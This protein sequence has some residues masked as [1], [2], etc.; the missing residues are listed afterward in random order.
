LPEDP[1][2][3]IRLPGIGRYTAGAVA[4]FAYEKAVPAVDTNVARV[5]RRV[6]FGERLIRQRIS[7]RRPIRQQVIWSLAAGLVPKDGKRAWKFNQ[8]IMELG[9]LICGARK[10]K[11][12]DCPVQVRCRTGRRLGRRQDARH[13]GVSLNV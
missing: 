7:R 10:P 2:E 4:S 1:E 8:A 11:C 5:I 6:F 13:L 9:A 3:L 12:G